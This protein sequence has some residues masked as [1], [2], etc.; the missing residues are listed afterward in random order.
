VGE[1]KGLLGLLGGG[2]DENDEESKTPAADAL[3]RAAVASLVP[4]WSRFAPEM[5]LFLLS[6]WPAVEG[7]RSL[8]ALPFGL[9]VR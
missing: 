3:G 5:R 2:E 7:E 1:P 9:R 4:E 8:A 6:V